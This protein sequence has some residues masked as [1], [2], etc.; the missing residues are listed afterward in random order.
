MNSNPGL[1]MAKEF[2]RH[3]RLS[4]KGLPGRGW[5]PVAPRKA[6]SGIIQGPRECGEHHRSRTPTHPAVHRAAGARSAGYTERAEN[7]PAFAGQ[8]YRETE[9]NTG[10]DANTNRPHCKRECF[11]FVTNRLATTADGLPIRLARGTSPAV[12]TRAR[13][14]T[15]VPGDGIPAGVDGRRRVASADRASAVLFL[16]QS[17]IFSQPTAAATHIRFAGMVHD[18]TKAPFRR[19]FSCVPSMIDSLEV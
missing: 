12:P 13:R 16:R 9:E 14:R 10:V 6:S 15:P 4:C 8:G 5:G 11:N 3:W 19:G 18:A 2:H 17:V 7:S 1:I